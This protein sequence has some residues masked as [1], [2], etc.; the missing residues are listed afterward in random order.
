M[1]FRTE[2]TAAFAAAGLTTHAQI[3]AALGVKRPTISQWLGGKTN[4]GPQLVGAY[5]R[6]LDAETTLPADER[7]LLAAYRRLPEHLRRAAIHMLGFLRHADMTARQGARQEPQPKSDALERIE[8]H[9]REISARMGRAPTP[10]T[11]MPI[12]EQTLNE[13]DEH[14]VDGVLHDP[15]FD[16]AQTLKTGVKV[17]GARRRKET[18]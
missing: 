1:K 4:A 7:D 8:R 3:A 16:T 13:S 18:P 2:A 12:V 10:E 17:P 6:W 11:P 9:K 5:A 14:H 15:E